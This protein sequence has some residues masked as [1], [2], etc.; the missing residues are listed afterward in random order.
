[1]RNL[2]FPLGTVGPLALLIGL[3]NAPAPGKAC[4]AT[5]T[6]GLE[7][8]MSPSLAWTP[9]AL[10]RLFPHL[11]LLYIWLQVK[12]GFPFSQQARECPSAEL[13]PEPEAT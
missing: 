10:G 3:A 5:G 2:G 9:P 8:F 6:E 1:M 7:K 13:E 12:R 4:S 11:P